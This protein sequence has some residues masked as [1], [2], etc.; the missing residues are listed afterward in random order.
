MR[1]HMTHNLEFPWEMP[2]NAIVQ[3]VGLE[4]LILKDEYN[5]SQLWLSFVHAVIMYTAP[6][7]P[8]YPK[9][10]L[11]KRAAREYALISDIDKVLYLPERGVPQLPL[12]FDGWRKIAKTAWR[13]LTE[14]GLPGWETKPNGKPLTFAHQLSRHGELLEYCENNC[15]GRYYSKKGRIYF[16]LIKDYTLARIA[17]GI[18]D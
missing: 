12:P 8:E 6:E 4:P 18:A 1:G 2:A 11:K 17:F 15:R 3:V 13:R 9:I 14:A 5:D 7:K 10:D 16:E